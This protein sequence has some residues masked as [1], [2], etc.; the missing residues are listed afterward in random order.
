MSWC[1]V[2][3]NEYQLFFCV[4]FIK[5][6]LWMEIRFTITVRSPK[7]CS[8]AFSWSTANYTDP[9]TFVM[10]HQMFIVWKT[11]CNKNIQ[12][13]LAQHLVQEHTTEHFF[14][15]SCWISCSLYSFNDNF[16]IP[17][18]RDRVLIMYEFTCVTSSIQT[19]MRFRHFF[20]LRLK[21]L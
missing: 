1:K 6:T 12:S 20:V 16:I 2:D 5:A 9:V 7:T 21:L 11:V 15:S 17:S 3:N 14:S 13:P 18:R 4:V 8:F 10:N 19:N